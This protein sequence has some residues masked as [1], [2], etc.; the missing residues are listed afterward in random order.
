MENQHY[1]RFIVLG[2]A[3][4]GGTHLTSCLFS[5]L[6][7]DVVSEPLNVEYDWP[8]Q[9]EVIHK[10]F[11]GEYSPVIQA[12]GF[13][14]KL[15]TIRNPQ[16]FCEL[17]TEL[18]CKLIHLK[19]TNLVKLAVS[20][21]RAHLLYQRLGMWNLSSALSQQEPMTVSQEVLR[22]ELEEAERL[23]SQLDAFVR[24]CALSTLTVTYEELLKDE[25]NCLSNI[26]T[27]LGV[28]PYALSSDTH[29]ITPDDLRHV[30]LN[31]HELR[32]IFAGTKYQAMFDEVLT[33]EEQA[34][35][36]IPNGFAEC[37]PEYA[38]PVVS[39]VVLTLNGLRHT[40]ECFRSIAAHTRVPYE[41]I[42]VDNASTDGTWEYLQS[43]QN[44]KLVRNETSRGFGPACNQ[45]AERARGKYVLFLNND[46]VV[47]PGWLTRLTDTMEE[48]PEC[49][50]VG[51]KL[52]HMDGTLQEAGGIIWRDGSTA[53]Y[54]RGEDPS[55]SA[56]N[57]LREVDYCSAACLLVRKDAWDAIGGFDPRYA[58]AYYEDV[59][60]CMKLRKAGYT[61]LC[62]PT[63][64]VRH[65]EY[66]SSSKESAVLLMQRN[67]DIFFA[68][69]KE[70]LHKHPEPF[71]V[72]LRLAAD[73]RKGK[74][75][76]VLDDRL[77]TPDQGMGYP[78][79]Y[80]LLEQ[81]AA[82]GCRVSLFP[83]NEKIPWEPHN[84]AL[85][86]KG[87]ETVLEPNV[88]LKSFAK[89][90]AGEYEIV[91]VSRPHNWKRN[92]G[93]L[94]A[95]FDSARFIYDA[96]AV[97]A[98]RAVL[99]AQHT[100]SWW[101]LLKARWALRKECKLMMHAHTIL[102]VSEAEKQLIESQIHHQHIR[103][104]G[105]PL[106]TNPTRSSFADRQGILF[107]GGGL[108]P[109]SPNE[110]A[111]CWYANNVHPEI[112]RE[113]CC[114]L[115]VVGH[116]QSDAVRALSSSAVHLWGFVP[117]IRSIY[118]SCRVFVAPTRIGAG[119][120]LKVHEAM[121]FGIPCV[122]TSL[123]AAQ[124]DGDAPVLAADTAQEFVRQI[125]RLYTDEKLWHDI[126]EKALAYMRKHC[127][128]KCLAAKTQNL[129]NAV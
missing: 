129:I 114:I 122:T 77:P 73:R 15:S 16:E 110:D 4:T 5:H 63:S 119:V 18:D 62:Q 37:F 49:G 125:Q 127:A 111:I 75:V 50:G 128:P 48:H 104:W 13:R 44:V 2:E 109:G 22:A 108:C 81:L 121:S 34:P 30:L 35:H 17:I 94:Y 118:D 33:N 43:L 58:P 82:V 83:L 8:S 31:F 102:A 71:S 41:V 113:L 61:V 70:E 27:F 66:G 11:S 96:E 6:N 38:T 47:L 26:C 19:R 72:P 115:H 78:R 3:R 91:L 42:V 32:S 53:G 101:N 54:G 59:D 69:W 89:E 76:L 46:T 24:N 10:F 39:I 99:R 67:R 100:G 28:R 25:A 51:A 20:R 55:S 65:H 84:T 79:A 120:P 116:V 85:R 23:E 9:R 93:I 88:T 87:V 64:E 107:V 56:Y 80:K 1:Q 106:K 97:F 52:L 12:V 40:R 86:G 14:E 21:I 126:R 112:Y 90:R 117:D 45:G 92:L 98:Q 29:K 60:L 95:Y 105:L 68:K 7:I 124:L 57:F 123:V 74:R 36:P 103:V